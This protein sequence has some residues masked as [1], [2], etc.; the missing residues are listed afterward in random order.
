MDDKTF[1]SLDI[2]CS[3]SQKVTLRRKY[4]ELNRKLELKL[5]KSESKLPEI[6]RSWIIIEIACKEQSIQF[7]KSKLLS[8]CVNVNKTNY[9]NAYLTCKRQ[10]GLPCIPIV[11]AEKLLAVKFSPQIVEGAKEYLEKNKLFQVKDYSETSFLCA[12]VQIV[13]NKVCK[14]S[15]LALIL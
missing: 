13:A 1:Q 2:K 3:E 5:P 6:C 8:F 9:R 11:D 10:L 15:F 7:S 14:F 12:A 4:E